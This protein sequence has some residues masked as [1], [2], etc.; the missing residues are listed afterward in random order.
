MYRGR[1]VTWI[2]TDK[3][4]NMPINRLSLP[5]KGNLAKAYAAGMATRTCTIK[6]PVHTTRP[7]HMNSPMGALLSTS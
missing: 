6:M 7:F 1:A 3:A 2:G 5:L 4:T